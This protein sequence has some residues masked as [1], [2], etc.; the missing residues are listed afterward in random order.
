MNPGGEVA[1]SARIGRME[2]QRVTLKA[3]AMKMAEVMA[4]VLG[5]G[6]TGR[7]LRHVGLLS[8]LVQEIVAAKHLPVALLLWSGQICIG[9]EENRPAGRHRLQQ[10]RRSRPPVQF[11][12]ALYPDSPTCIV[13]LLTATQCM[14]NDYSPLNSS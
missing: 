10:G 3:K 9:F 12:P 1:W 13:H 11:W 14:R 4:I 5:Q 8:R 7:C 6:Q 2:T